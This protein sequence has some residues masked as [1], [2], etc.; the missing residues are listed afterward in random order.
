MNKSC[1]RRDDDV[2][3]G[4]N[5]RHEVAVDV[6]ITRRE[7]IRQVHEVQ[8][9]RVIVRTLGDW[10]DRAPTT[11]GKRDSYRYDADES[12]RQHCATRR[13]KVHTPF[14][15]PPERFQPDFAR[16]TLQISAGLRTPTGAEALCLIRLRGQ[17]RKRGYDVDDSHARAAD[18][19][20]YLSM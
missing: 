15:Q 2:A 13:D 4:R 1:G 5:R 10:G 20:A 12:G 9:A 3:A 18:C 14:P 7:I 8:V 11:R 19:R 6:R 16:E 17:F